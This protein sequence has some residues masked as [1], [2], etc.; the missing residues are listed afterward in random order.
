M[1][2]LFL[3]VQE[4]LVSLTHLFRSQ[5]FELRTVR[6][7][8]YANLVWRRSFSV[9]CF[10]FSFALYLYFRVLLF[11]I[12]RKINSFFVILN[13]KSFQYFVL[14]LIDLLILNLNFFFTSRRPDLKL[15]WFCNTSFGF[16]SASLK[17]LNNFIRF[18]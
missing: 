15:I 17:F 16:P 3:L 10:V 6:D 7:L 8:S 12:S 4:L 1:Y 11:I 9:F 2:Y 5:Y 14:H 13:Q 18:W